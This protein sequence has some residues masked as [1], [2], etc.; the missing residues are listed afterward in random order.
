MKNSEKIQEKGRA[1]LRV[2]DFFLV[3]E[4]VFW[5]NYG[6]AIE[7]FFTETAGVLILLATFG[8]F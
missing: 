3:L 1:L 7:E 5:P 6:S 2:T 8:Y 4:T